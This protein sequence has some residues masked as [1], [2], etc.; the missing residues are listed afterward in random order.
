MLAREQI[1]SRKELFLLALVDMI[2]LSMQL[3]FLY[4]FPFF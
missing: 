1:P 3:F 4:F 2:P